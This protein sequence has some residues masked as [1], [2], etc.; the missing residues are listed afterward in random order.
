MLRA[1]LILR[2][3]QNLSQQKDRGL[4]CT[5]SA[6]SL[7]QWNCLGL[8]KSTECDCAA[9]AAQE[10]SL[11]FRTN[12]L[13]SRMEVFD[14]RK[15]ICCIHLF[16][17]RSAIIGGAVQGSKIG[18]VMKFQPIIGPL[19]TMMTYCTLC[20]SLFQPM[21]CLINLKPA[22]ACA[23]WPSTYLARCQNCRSAYKALWRFPQPKSIHFICAQKEN[24]SQ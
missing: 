2:L 3:L 4:T 5:H 15:M 22:R 7:L 8:E 11:G 21:K 10:P 13:A 18:S 9:I 23:S 12:C 17:D 1:V 19:S 20:L 16:G 24:Y 6:K 14:P